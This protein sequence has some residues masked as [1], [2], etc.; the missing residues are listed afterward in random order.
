MLAFVMNRR[1]EYL[2]ECEVVRAQVSHALVASVLPVTELTLVI[3]RATTMRKSSVH[4]IRPSHAGSLVSQVS[5]AHL[6][7]KLAE[8][9][10]E[11]EALL[12]IETLSSEFVRRLE[13][14]D[15]DCT[16]MA[17]A[18]KGTLSRSSAFCEMI[19][20]FAV[21]GDA[22]CQWSEMFRILDLCG[23]YTIYNA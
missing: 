12:A 20:S 19:H 18:E 13:S 22:L 15:I 3:V 5:N 4:S 14:V 21:F 2:R 11:F 1:N 7:A 10:K 17:D 16:V 9:K 23:G 8:E 6:K